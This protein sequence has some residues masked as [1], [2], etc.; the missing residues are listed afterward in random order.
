MD[1]E[2]HSPKTLS[3]F[4]LEASISAYDMQR[5]AFYA[6]HL[7]SGLLPAYART[8]DRRDI[9]DFHGLDKYRVRQGF[10]IDAETGMKTRWE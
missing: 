9:S 2:V 3:N 1:I 6:L 5:A 8:R 4:E 10:Q 7:T